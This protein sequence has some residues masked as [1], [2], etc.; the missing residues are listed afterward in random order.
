MD[1]AWDD[2]R[3]FL[4][5]WETGSLSGAAERLGVAQATMSR[6]MAALED[7]VGH[8]LFDRSRT[9]LLPTVAAE[10][11]LPHA[12]AMAAAAGSAEAALS[13]LERAPRG[14]VRVAVPPGLAFDVFP[15]LLPVVRARYPDLRLEVLAGNF[16]VD[17]LRREADLAIRTARPT[18]GDL[19]FR[20]LPDVPIHAYAHPAYLKSIGRGTPPEDIEWIQYSEDMLHIP[21]A[22]WVERARGKRPV[23]FS[24]NSFL[25]MRQAAVHGA[26]AMLLPSG[27]AEPHGL[28]QLD[29][30]D[31]QVPGVAWYLV[32]HRA[33]Q[34]V[35]RIRAV[36]E[37]IDETVAALCGPAPARHN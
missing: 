4:A 15:P 33:L 21:F 11:L 26:G 36:V 14:R 19:V 6:R 37:L 7:Q 25:A 34:R 18:H 1:L 31:V 9:G 3:L 20:A 5:A 29:W 13:G 2:M 28:V 16:P 24:S 30:I 17:L 12:E 8:V 22:Q 23:A 32:I 27:Q 35:P 10:Q